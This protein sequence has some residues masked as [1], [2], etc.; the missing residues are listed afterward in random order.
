MVSGLEQRAETREVWVA[1]IEHAPTLRNY[2]E[3]QT[4]RVLPA[5]AAHPELPARVTQARAAGGPEVIAAACTL[6]PEM[7]REDGDQR[8]LDDLGL[9][10]DNRV[11]GDD[12]ALECRVQHATDSGRGAQGV[13]VAA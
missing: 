5:P 1:G 10:T 4:Y 9:A 7:A 3:R 2:L 13:Q 11:E 6:Y 12:E 8:G